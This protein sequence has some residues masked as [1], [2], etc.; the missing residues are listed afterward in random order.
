MSIL[1]IFQAAWIVQHLILY[2]IDTNIIISHIFHSHS[3][4]LCYILILFTVTRT[5]HF[6]TVL[7]FFSFLKF[8]FCFFFSFNSNCFKPFNSTSLSRYFK[9]FKSNSFN[10]FEFNSIIL[11]LLFSQMFNSTPISKSSFNSLNSLLPYLNRLIL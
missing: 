6:Q 10:Q 1:L 5:C 4:T 7:I 8:L 3:L 2:P 11:L 9:Q